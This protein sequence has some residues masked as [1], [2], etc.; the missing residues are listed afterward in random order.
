MTRDLHALPGGQVVVN[1]APGL[2]DLRFDGLDFRIEIDVVL[3]G[4]ILQILQ[5]ALQFEDRLFEI[6]RLQ[7]HLVSP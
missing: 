3:V 2:V 5:P 7:F 4:M 6:E 1:L